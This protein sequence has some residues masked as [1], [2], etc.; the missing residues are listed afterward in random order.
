[1][2]QSPF[3]IPLRVFGCCGKN[4]PPK[5][6]DFKWGVLAVENVPNA[7][8]PSSPSSKNNLIKSKIIL[9]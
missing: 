6:L 5:P 8:H 2:R 4:V 7:H 3:H 9:D 1:M